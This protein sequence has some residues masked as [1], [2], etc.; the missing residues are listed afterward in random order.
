MTR[1]AFNAVYVVVAVALLPWV[2]LRLLRG[3]R[4]VAAPLARAIGAV[5]RMPPP[6]HAR[7][8]RRIWLHGVSVGEVNL[9]HTL[10]QVLHSIDPMVECIASSSTTTGIDLARRK[11]GDHSTFACP[12]DFS[13]AV[14]RVL[15][16]VAPDLLVLG[17]LELWPNLLDIAHARGIPIAVVNARMSPRSFRG[18]S[19][20]TPFVQRM[21]RRIDLVA[22]RSPDDAHRF[23]TLGAEHVFMSGSMKF[24]GVIGDRMSPAILALRS[25]ANILPSD[26]VFLAGSTQSPEELLAIKTFCTL[27]G[28]FPALRLILVPRHTERCGSIATMLDDM[29]VHWQLRS[30][31]NHENIHSSARVLLVDSIGELSNW[32]GTARIAFVGGSLDGHRGG[33]NMIE[34]AAYGCAVAF[35][36]HTFNFQTEVQELLKADASRVIDD[37]DSLTD[38]VR[39]CLL[40]SEWAEQL[41]KRA[42]ALVASRRGVTQATAHAL[43]DI[44]N[45]RCSHN[46]GTQTTTP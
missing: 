22:A 5:R 6:D 29:Q 1:W 28:E 39:K 13:W 26:V 43:F 4:P 19:R 33:Q 24:D 15:D 12:L 25:L 31:L 3:G 8:I 44:L 40:E 27:C 30:R 35:G 23:S 36:P 46:A 37:G 45:R 34:P 10:S 9:L 32:W 11:F 38:F 41:G 17:E 42:A 7:G 14:R 20:I 18:Y 21:L 2:F 16:R